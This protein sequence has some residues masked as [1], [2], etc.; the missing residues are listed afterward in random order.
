MKKTF[1]ILQPNAEN[2]GS[3]IPFTDYRWIGPYVIEKVSPNDN[4]IVRRLNTDKTQIL[5]RIRLKKNVPNTPLEEKYSKEKLQPDE[6]VV[7]PQDDLYTISWE[8]DFDYQV[9]QPRQD[10]NANTAN[11][12]DVLDDNA[13]D[14]EIRPRPATS[15]EGIITRNENDVTESTARNEQQDESVKITHQQIMKFITKSQTFNYQGRSSNCGTL[16][17]KSPMWKK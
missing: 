13:A 10:D 15:S 17:L 3:K 14:E 9:F 6:E 12:N 8:A 16:I 11:N 2:Q 1:F 7:I 4:Y 5:H